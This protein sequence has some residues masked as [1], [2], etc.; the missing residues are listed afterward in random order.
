MWTIFKKSTHVPQLVL[1][2]FKVR[3]LVE[4]PSPEGAA[5]VHGPGVGAPHIRGSDV[6]VVVGLQAPGA[7]GRRPLGRRPARDF[8]ILIRKKKSGKYFFSFLVSY[9]I[10]VCCN[11]GGYSSVIH[12]IS[13]SSKEN[14]QSGALKKIDKRSTD[15]KTK[16]SA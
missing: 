1:V 10:I 14:W 12:N 4:H 7:G 2:Q 3:G 8:V 16:V 6:G 5:A 9:F 15:Q 13:P 11:A